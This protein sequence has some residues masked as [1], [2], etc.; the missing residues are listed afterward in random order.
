MKKQDN[1]DEFET[2]ASELEC[3]T[4]EDVMD[5]VFANLEL[6]PGSN[7]ESDEDK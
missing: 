7:Q 3:D 2:V 5:K 1:K 4:S 6:K